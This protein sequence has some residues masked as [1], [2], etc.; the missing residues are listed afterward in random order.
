MSEVKEFENV[1]NLED[2]FLSREFGKSDVGSPASLRDDT[3]FGGA[4]TRAPLVPRGVAPAVVGVHDT[5][6]HLRRNRM[7]ATVSGVAA[8][9]LVAVGFVSGTGKP[10]KTGGQVSAIQPTTTTTPTGP[11]KTSGGQPSPGSPNPTSGVITTPTGIE[12]SAVSGGNSHAAAGTQPDGVTG[13]GHQTPPPPTTKPGTTT[14][15]A[16]SGSVLSPVVDLVGQVVV[17]TG[18]TVSG[19]ST[20]L[21]TALPPLAPVTSVVGGLG[22]TVTGLGDSLITSA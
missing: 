19:A 21:T 22:G 15:T 8:A 5:A 1:T 12:L 2:L 7:I 14:P 16:P 10:G 3:L 20:T 18:N 11:T 9:L 4:P 13:G 17:T 6:T